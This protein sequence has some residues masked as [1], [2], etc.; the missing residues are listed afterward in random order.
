MDTSGKEAPS[1]DR[2]YADPITAI[3]ALRQAHLRGLGITTGAA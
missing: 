2:G 1:D 3:T